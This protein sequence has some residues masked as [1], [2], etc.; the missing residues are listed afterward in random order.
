M[1]SLSLLCYLQCGEIF[2]IVTLRQHRKVIVERTKEYVDELAFTAE[3]IDEDGGKNYHAWAHRY[4]IISHIVSFTLTFNLSLIR[5]WVVETFR[6]WQQDL[7]YIEECF[8]LDLRNNS[9]WN[10][11]YFVISKWKTLTPEVIAEEIQ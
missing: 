1:V 2:I 9:A 5:Q 7:N 11:R 8:K 4:V 6:L 10:E 3:M